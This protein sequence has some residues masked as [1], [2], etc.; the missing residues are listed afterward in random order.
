MNIGKYYAAFKNGKGC[1]MF[2]VIKFVQ[3]E[4]VLHRL[5]C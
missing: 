1:S 2:I 4:V 3:W 5:D